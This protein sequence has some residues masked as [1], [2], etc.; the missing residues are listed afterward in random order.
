MNGI[1][2][3]SITLAI[4]SILPTENKAVQLTQRARGE[5][6]TD[7]STSALVVPSE[8]PLPPD[9]EIPDD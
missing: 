6:F 7:I 1:F 2:R 9:E 3:S 8:E 5:D 4:M